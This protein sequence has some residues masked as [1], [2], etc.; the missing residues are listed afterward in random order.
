MLK[1]KDF[2]YLQRN[3]RQAI[4]FCSVSSSFVLLSLS[5]WEK[6]IRKNQVWKTTIL[7]II[8]PKA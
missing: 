7:Q 4:W 2:F 3:D 5:L 8:T 1:L 6:S